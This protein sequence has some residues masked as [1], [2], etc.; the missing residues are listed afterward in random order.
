MRGLVSRFIS[1]RVVYLNSF[2][3]LVVVVLPVNVYFGNVLYFV[4]GPVVCI[5]EPCS[6]VLFVALQYNVV[7]QVRYDLGFD[8]SA[9]SCY[10]VYSTAAFFYEV[11]Q[12]W[13]F[14]S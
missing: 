11:I 2:K 12:A 4:F 13:L 6:S 8:Y 7:V 3:I 14:S 10:F 1:D 5:D 9:P